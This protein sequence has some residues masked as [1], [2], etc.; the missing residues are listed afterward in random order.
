MWN[1]KMKAVTLSYDDGIFQDIRLIEILDQY[2]LRATFNINLGRQKETDTF[3][4]SGVMV[5]HI[6]ASELPKVY[7]DHEVAGHTYMHV[8][9]ETLDDKAAREEIRRCHDGL[10]QL[11]SREIIGMAYPYG[12]YNDRTVEL[13]QEE[14]VQ[15]SRT[16]IQTERFDFPTDLLRLPTTCRHANIKLL[17]IAREFVTLKPDKPQLLYLW[18][19][20]YEFDEFNNWD[21]IEEFC[22]VVSGY[23]DIFYGTNSEVLLGVKQI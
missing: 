12:T 23:D 20:S 8:H 6:N 10:Q 2:G 5:Q 17:D 4:K 13:L 22:R 21:L 18:G 19:H 3:M 11:F 16:C 9:L 15:Y 7:A 1:N 14:G